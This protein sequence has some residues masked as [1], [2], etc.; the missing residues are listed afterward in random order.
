MVFIG[1]LVLNEISVRVK[2]LALNK[3]FFRLNLGE[4]LF[5]STITNLL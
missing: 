5:T 1:S 4:N 2:I 3:I